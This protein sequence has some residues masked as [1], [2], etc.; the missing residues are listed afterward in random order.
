M[1]RRNKVIDERAVTT[2]AVISA[3]PC[4]LVSLVLVGAVGTA[5]SVTLYDHASAAT[6]NK[7]KVLTTSDGTSAPTTVPYCPCK[8]DAFSNGMFV[9]VTGTGAMAYISI[10][11][12]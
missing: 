11:P 10:E 8:A 12:V 1:A 2:G 7:K 6:G 4:G 3:V 9:V 5:S